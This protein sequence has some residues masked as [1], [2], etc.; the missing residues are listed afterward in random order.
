M[1]DDRRRRPRPRAR[2]RHALL[3]P[4]GAD[5]AGRGG[6]H[7]A[8]PREEALDGDHRGRRGG[9]AARRSAPRTAPAS[10]PT[11][12]PAPSRWSR[13]GCSPTASPTRRRSTASCRLG[14]G[15]R[16]GPFELIDLIGLDVNLSV[17]RSFYAQGGEPERWRPSPIQ[18]RL[19]AEGRLGRKSGQRLLRL[20]RAAATATPRSRRSGIDGADP[21]PR[22]SWRRST[23][24]RRRS[25][26]ASSPRSPTRP[27]SPWKR[28]SA[29][30]QDMDTAMRLGFN[31]PLG[32]LEFTELIGAGARRRAA[33]AA[34]RRARRRL[35][36]GA[37]ACSPR[38]RRAD[39]SAGRK[40]ATEHTARATAR[41]RLAAARR[42]GGLRGGA[43]RPRRRLRPAAG[44][45]RAAARVVWDLESYDFLDGEP[46]DT[47]HPSLWR[48][49]QLN[50][51]AGLF[52][53]APGFYQLRG[54]DLSNM[55][56]I[57]GERG[58]RRDRP[59]GLRRDRRRGARPLPRAPRRAP[60]HRPDLHP[61]PRRPL[62]RRQGRRLATRRSRRAGSRSS[63][64]PAS[65][66]TR[67]ARTSSPAPRWARRAGYMYGAL[68]ER[69]PDGQ[70]G[71]GLGQTTSLGHDHPDPA[72]PRRSPRPA[73][74]RPS[75]ACGWSSSSRPGTEAPAEMNFHF[76]DAA[77]ALHRRQRDPLDAQHPHPARRPGPRPARLGAL[78][79]RGDRAVR[80]R[81]RRPLRRPPLAALGQRADRRLP[82]EAARPL[83]LP[84][85]PDPAPAQP[86][87]DRAGDRRADRAAAE[88]RRASGTAASTTARSATT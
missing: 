54:F 62:R 85:R 76:P 80:R 41:R 44:R 42:R 10:S 66:T 81:L 24:P 83:R 1:T 47:A 59:A 51:I 26:P 55:H 43:P 13:C 37:A 2:R 27:P 17:A 79:R 16:M 48:Q 3:Q 75:T 7:R 15:F 84:A 49:S 28:R 70:V 71:S 31:W 18:E 60:G 34:A 73:R 22:A 20:R 64:R 14:G 35:P 5:E 69:G 6:R 50:R 25:S 86:G 12:S 8:T 52:E 21:R 46:P 58:D 40:P 23:R 11:A 45:G 53:L 68:L 57:E 88:P 67:S 56:V 29:R 30:P 19:V 82:R 61:Q 63:P 87:P 36:P 9:W 4:A 74:R 33:R 65:S 39:V 38:P 72:Q 78:P 32:P 77:R